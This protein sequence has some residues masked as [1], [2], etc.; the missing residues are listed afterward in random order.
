MDLHQN[1]DGGTNLGYKD[2]TKLTPRKYQ[3]AIGGI[4]VSRVSHV[5]F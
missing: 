3:Y 1:G 4:P 5:E 2:S